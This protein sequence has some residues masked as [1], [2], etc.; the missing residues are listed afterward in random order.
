M[1]SDV[2]RIISVISE[3]NESDGAI[4]APDGSKM[5]T[6]QPSDKKLTDDAAAAKAADEA[7]E[8]EEEGPKF[9]EDEEHII[10]Y[11]KEDEPLP[12]ELLDKIVQPWWTEEPFK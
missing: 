10:Q 6:A 4:T 8:E 12:A 1:P 2:T 11:L 9:T 3:D 5:S 7:G